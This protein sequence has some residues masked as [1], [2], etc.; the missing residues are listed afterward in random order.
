MFR[1]LGNIVG[2]L[3]WT[4][5]CLV[6]LSWAFVAF[7]GSVSLPT[8]TK[9]CD[10][11]FRHLVIDTAAPKYKKVHNLKYRDFVSRME[12]IASLHRDVKMRMIGYS[13]GEI[14]QETEYLFYFEISKTRPIPMYAL[15]IGPSEEKWGS[16]VVVAGHHA[17]EPAGPVAA[18]EFAERLLNSKTKFG[19]MLKKNYSITIIPVVD[20]DHFSL[21]FKDR[22]YSYRTNNFYHRTDQNGPEWE[23]FRP[24]YDRTLQKPLRAGPES[25]NVARAIQERTMGREFALAFD[26]HEAAQKDSGMPHDGFFIATPEQFDRDDLLDA[27]ANRLTANKIPIDP[28]WKWRQITLGKRFDQFAQSLGATSFTQES[29]R[30]EPDGTT[31]RNP[32]ARVQMHLESMDEI[33]GRYLMLKPDDFGKGTEPE[34]P[35]SE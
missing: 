6:Y 29:P 17:T 33:I 7:F 1:Y 12:Q 3:D 26:L 28:I 22:V 24:D 20:V 27:V 16:I 10:E 25:R 14:Y 15:D 4:S 31:I 5:K 30:F 18:L 19:E 11:P 9:K 13:G 34:S 35:S 8:E 23:F 32:S 21:K 2:Q